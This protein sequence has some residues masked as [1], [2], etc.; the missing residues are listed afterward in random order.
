MIK[1]I[2]LDKTN[3]LPDASIASGKKQNTTTSQITSLSNE[4]KQNTDITIM[5]S[6]GDKVTLSSSMEASY[7][8]YE[9][10]SRSKAEFSKF[11][12]QNLSF[13]KSL[14]ISV[15]G[16]LSE[17]ELKDIQTAVKTIGKAFEDFLSGDV[18]KATDRVLKIGEMDSISSLEAT[19]EQT[20]EQNF[21]SQ[22]TT[23]TNEVL[24]PIDPMENINKLTDDM[25]N[26][27]KDAGIKKAD[28]LK[29]SLNDLFG[30]FLKNFMEKK[31]ESKI[32]TT[33]IVQQNLME[34]IDKIFGENET[35]VA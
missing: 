21:M 22:T 2:P 32:Q 12:S 8:G 5:T 7:S 3:Y 23:E 13:S 34:K 16:N 25:T 9:N 14:A 26:I 15:E 27:A 11:Q 10:I 4:S 19:L 1:S 6:E 17:D 30:D 18:D 31:D 33:N 24:S 35:S 29:K 20:I 28:T